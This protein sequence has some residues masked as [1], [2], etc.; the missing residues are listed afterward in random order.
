MST[1]TGDVTS[2]DTAKKYEAWGWEVVTIDG[3]N[4]E[5]IRNALTKGITQQEKPFL[6]IGKTIMG[7]GACKDNGESFEKKVSTHGSYNFV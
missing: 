7:K 4:Q 6:I 3:N 2:E 5:E 1:E